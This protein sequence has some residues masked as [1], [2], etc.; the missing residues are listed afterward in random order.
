MEVVEVRRH[1]VAVV[2]ENTWSW[3][4]MF[5]KRRYAASLPTL[6]SAGLFV[7]AF[8]SPGIWK[9]FDFVSEALWCQTQA[10]VSKRKRET[11][12]EDHFL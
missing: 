6:R 9:N 1:R 12:E 2:K 8:I 3:C 10:K 7:E 4:T 5:Q 11:V